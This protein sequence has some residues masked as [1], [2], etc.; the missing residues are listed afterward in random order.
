VTPPVLSPVVVD[1]DVASF[2]FKADSRAERYR[3]HL[4]GRQRVLAF[5]SVAEM[6]GWARERNWGADRQAQL[7]AYLDSFTIEHSDA[8]LC[9]WW[10]A[11]RSA[12][13]SAGKPIGAADAWIAATALRYDV[14]L[15]THNAADF[16]GVPGLILI[17]EPDR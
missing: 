10:A 3:A 14:P 8:V 16:A 13:R 5:M 6:R 7:A 4:E 15:V 11:V 12:T 1:T 9:E 17:T 2:R